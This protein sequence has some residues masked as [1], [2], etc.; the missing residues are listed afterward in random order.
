MEKTII[1]FFLILFFLC[2]VLGKICV[3]KFPEM[4]SMISLTGYVS[5][6]IVLLGIPG[7]SWVVVIMLIG[8]MPV[9]IEDKIFFDGAK[10]VTHL[11]ILMVFGFFM[12]MVYLL[13]I[14]MG[15]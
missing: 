12:G 3:K 7:T 11:S 8:A 1:S 5:I 6:L 2:L 14:I 13:P 4:A 10:K 9:L 15:G